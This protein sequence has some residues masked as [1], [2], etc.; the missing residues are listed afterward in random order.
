MSYFV[1]ATKSSNP[2][3]LKLSRIILPCMVYLWSYR[4]IVLVNTGRVRGIPKNQVSASESLTSRI[5]KYFDAKLWSYSESA[6][7]AASNHI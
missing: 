1:N 5:R 4:R 6:C 2:I 3:E 7:R